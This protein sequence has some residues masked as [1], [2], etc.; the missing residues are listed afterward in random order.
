M[1]RCQTFHGLYWFGQLSTIEEQFEEYWCLNWLW[2]WSNTPQAKKWLWERCCRDPFPFFIL[3]SLNEK[4]V[5]ALCKNAPRS[6]QSWFSPPRKHALVLT[7]PHS[8]GEILIA[9]HFNVV[10]K[11][12]RWLFPDYFTHLSAGT[13]SFP[14]NSCSLILQVLNHCIDCQLRKE[15]LGNLSKTT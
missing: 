13:T 5:C 6:P 10:F 4:C 8:L 11:I 1:I 2:P 9:V 7:M 3:W 15:L 14:V 12:F